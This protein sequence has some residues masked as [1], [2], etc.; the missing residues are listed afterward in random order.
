MQRR[1]WMPKKM[2]EARLQA[3]PALGDMTP[4]RSTRSPTPPSAASAETY[5]S[6]FTCALP[7]APARIG[8][9]S[10]CA[11]GAH[12]PSSWFSVVEQ[13]HIPGGAQHHRRATSIHCRRPLSWHESDLSMEMY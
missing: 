3:S 13:M 4:P 9:T 2:A 1:A 12:A 7:L 10:T 5:V 8:T 11:R 6:G